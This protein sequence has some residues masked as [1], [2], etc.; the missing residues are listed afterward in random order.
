MTSDIIDLLMQSSTRNTINTQPRIV[1]NA[2]QQEA[3]DI[4]KNFKNGEIRLRQATN[5]A[6]LQVV[7]SMMS[8]ADRHERYK[9]YSHFLN[10]LHDL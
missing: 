6:E 2:V 4:M 9:K 10:I 1:N 3:V 8:L 7:Q 5:S